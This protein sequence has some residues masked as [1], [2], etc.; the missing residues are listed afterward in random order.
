MSLQLTKEEQCMLLCTKFTL[1]SE[2]LLHLDAFLLKITDWAAFS[3]KIFQNG[4]APLVYNTLKKIPNKDKIPE[5]VFNNFKK[6]YINI[7]FKNKLKIKDFNA[8]TRQ[9][10]EMNIDFIPLK[11]MIMIQDI[12]GDLGLRSMSDI[13]MLV[14]KED[15]EKCKNIF[16]KSNWE[17]F[18]DPAE[19]EYIAQ[20]SETHHPYTFTFGYTKIELHKHLHP[21]LYSYQI[22]M[23]DYWERAHKIDFQ[24]VSAFNFAL[25][26]FILYLC[27]HQ[28]K[29]LTAES[30]VSMKHFCD[31]AEV[32]R[33]HEHEIIWNTLLERCIQYNCV[34][35]VREIL[36]ICKDYFYAP[37]AEINITSFKGKS[38]VDCQFLFI[39]YLRNNHVEI[40]SYLSKINFKHKVEKFRAIPSNRKKITFLFHLIFPSK[41]FMIKNYAVKNKALLPFYYLK[42]FFFDSLSGFKK[43]K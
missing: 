29:H 1:S 21:S 2:E 8:I 43:T 32:F 5:H 10:N 11:G 34:N 14:R 40:E 20:V 18:D 33:K 30:S 15:V 28:H 39:N 6:A 23:D 27:I 3:K 19:S 38:A 12:Y 36:S 13:D 37:I 42:R 22:N 35:E 31:I 17:I 4:L 16:L 25:L 7:L 9:L 41:E 26:D 24:G